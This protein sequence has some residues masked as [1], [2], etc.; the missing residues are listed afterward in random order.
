MK[1]IHPHIL[2]KE[3]NCWIHVSLREPDAEAIC[4]DFLSWSVGALKQF[5]Q[6]LDCTGLHRGS[7]SNSNR[8]DLTSQEMVVRVTP[9]GVNKYMEV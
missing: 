4:W 3:R 2:F 8:Y 6:L 7:G 1:T 9:A 5:L